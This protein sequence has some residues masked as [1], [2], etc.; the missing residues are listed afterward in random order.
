MSI[1]SQFIKKPR[2]SVS[3]TVKAQLQRVHDEPITH[4]DFAL[5]SECNMSC[6]LCHNRVLKTV[7]GQVASKDYV[8]IQIF[9][10]NLDLTQQ[11]E[12]LTVADLPTDYESLDNKMLLCRNC[13]D[14]YLIS[15]TVDEFQRLKEIKAQQTKDIAFADMADSINIEQGIL[16]I[17]DALSNDKTRP[18]PDKKSSYEVWWVS[19]KISDDNWSLQDKVT[20]WVL[21]YYRKIEE[22]F[23]E[24]ERMRTLRFKKVKNEVSQMF[25]IYDEQDLPQE[26]IFERMLNWLEEQTGCRDRK[27][28]EAFISFFIQNCEVFYE[29]TE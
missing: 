26:E 3:K 28:R 4:G 11:A 19:D 16:E 5:L 13:A 12:F 22:F 9:P 7:K 20:Y 1:L 25:E 8:A 2:K 6:P 21:R 17:L 14:A 10:E 29:T 15:P 18:R 24:R 23:E 27:A